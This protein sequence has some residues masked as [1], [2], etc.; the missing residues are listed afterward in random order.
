MNRKVNGMT[1][2]LPTGSNPDIVTEA[3]ARNL[4][5]FRHRHGFSLDQLARAAQVSKGTLV[6]IEQGR[7]NPSIG[8]LCRIASVLRVS[9]ADLVDVSQ[10]DPVIIAEAATS[11]VLWTGRNGGEGRLLLGSKAPDMMELWSWHMHPGDRYEASAHS[12]GT[13]E[14]LTVSEG[15]LIIETDG[16]TYDIETG[17][18]AQLQADRAHTYAC[19]G[20]TVTR[21]HMSVVEWQ[22]LRPGAGD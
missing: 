6:Q 11:P 7:A 9:V 14:F 13:V 17:Q 4:Q 15:R 2:T 5:D 16:R 10:S 8:V 12:A 22:K 1:D 19:G 18:S 20:K 21:F 3:V